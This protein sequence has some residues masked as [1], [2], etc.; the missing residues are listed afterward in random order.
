MITDAQ[1]EA[2]VSQAARRA[3]LD[4]SLV[5]GYV[6]EFATWALADYDRREDIR[7][8]YLPCV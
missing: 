2:A 6:R 5:A 7:R 4:A 3:I 8:G 1:F